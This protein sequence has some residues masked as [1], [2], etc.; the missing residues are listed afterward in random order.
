MTDR[1]EEILKDQSLVSLM[2]LGGFIGEIVTDKLS[3]RYDNEVF[4][5][6]KKYCGGE[7]Y[8]IVVADKLSELKDEGDYFRAEVDEN[9]NPWPNVRIDS[10]FR[11]WYLEQ[12]ARLLCDKIKTKD[13]SYWRQWNLSPGAKSIFLEFNEVEERVLYLIKGLDSGRVRTCKQVADMSE[14]SCD[15][16]YIVRIYGR[17][18]YLLSLHDEVRTTVAHCVETE[19]QQIIKDKK[20]IKKMETDFTEKTE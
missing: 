2:N 18:Q 14:F 5:I 12:E 3:S 15:S 19:R 4:E 6:A 11:S 9:D 8:F 1:R 13:E 10:Q 7:P 20:A 17:I 16:I